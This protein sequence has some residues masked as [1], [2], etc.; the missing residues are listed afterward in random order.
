MLFIYTASVL[1]N[2]FAN[3]SFEKNIERLWKPNTVLKLDLYFRSL[4]GK[5]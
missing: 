2:R 3:R 4:D 5:E 1:L